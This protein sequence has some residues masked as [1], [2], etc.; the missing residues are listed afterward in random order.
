MKP[1][2][3]VLQAAFH[4]H[5]LNQPGDIAC[6]VAEGGGI[7]AGHRLHIYHHA[8]R[9]RLLEA[10][11]D[12]FEKTWAY[13][14]DDGF[15]SAALAFIEGNPPTQRNLRW[16]GDGFPQWLTRLFPEDADIAEIALIDWQLRCAFDGPDAEPISPDDLAG[17]DARLWETAGFRF[18]PTLFMTP[19]KTNS[20]GIWH[21]LDQGRQPP[22][23]QALPQAAWLLV[24]R[25]GWQ[26]HFRCIEAA[27]HDALSAL[28][29]GASFAQ[30]CTGLS[31]Q[32]S[33]DAAASMAAG[34]LHAWLH[35]GM[36]IGLR[37]TAAKPA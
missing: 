13:L 19:L 10:L 22:A 5:L 14:G 23:A 16:Y 20:T 33:E 37:D 25:K 12:A 4:G 24:W 2:L 34:F 8:Y 30:T 31:R 6:E 9:A 32:F 7:T 11:Q 27:E 1:T 15:K 28:L 18:A 36:I 35:D 26:P 29:A 3:S 21:A 17:L